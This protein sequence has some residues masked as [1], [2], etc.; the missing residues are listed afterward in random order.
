MAGVIGE[1][2]FINRK[3]LQRE[4]YRDFSSVE[5][6]EFLQEAINSSPYISAILNRN[7]QV[8][9]TNSHL[10]KHSTMEGI[11][12]LIGERPGEVIG[13]IHKEEK[14][15]CGTTAS[16][17][18]CGILKTVQQS[19]EKAIRVSNECTITSLEK[20]K[21]TFY[22][23]RVTCSPIYFN[24]EMYTLMNLL[25]IGSERRNAILENVF[26]HDMLNRLGGLS[27]II[28]LIKT[29]NTQP[30]L[31]E[32][33]DMLETIGEMVIED[34]QTQRYLKA[35]E[36][37]NLILN[38][39]EHSAFDIIEAVRKQIAFH[40]VMNSMHMTLA[41]TCMDFKLQTDSTLLKR[42]LLN[43]TK[44]AAEAT[45]ENGIIRISGSCTDR[46]A[47]FSVNNPGMIQPDVQF[48][49]FQRSYTTKGIGR[50]LGTYSMKL[51]GEKYLKGKVYF[52]SDEKEGTTFTIEL[53]LL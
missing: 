44:N 18:F 19:Q 9:L 48:Q 39:R 7:R 52:E 22:D 49:I 51:Y 42:I 38:I 20:D 31:G 43:M 8:I 13:C 37:D 6:L 41:S 35:A 28:Q 1:K 53:P 33:I 4:L 30:E 21:P 29:S 17:R 24:G 27:G 25:D 2:H 3:T 16:C 5:Y 46:T 10:V 23:L 47:V 26:F 40:P 32:Y 15:G 14:S 50:G 36:N 11:E 12:E 34:I 45:P